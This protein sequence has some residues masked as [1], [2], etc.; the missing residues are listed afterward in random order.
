MRNLKQYPITTEEIKGVLAQI[1]NEEVR[2]DGIGSIR[3]A[4]IQKAIKIIDAADKMR[5]GIDRRFMG[6]AYLKWVTPWAEAAKLNDAFDD[7][8]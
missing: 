6:D 7:I 8:G 3:G 1:L 2:N 4:C 5:D